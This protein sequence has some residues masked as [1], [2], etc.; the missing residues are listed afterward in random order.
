M[1]AIISSMIL[2]SEVVLARL[3]VISLVVYYITFAH[4]LQSPVVAPTL[5]TVY[6]HIIGA[7]PMVP[8]ASTTARALSASHRCSGAVNP[9]QSTWSSNLP[10]IVEI[11]IWHAE[12][13]L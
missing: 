3:G 5:I 7:P 4:W 12:H 2:H 10:T 6:F 8:M 13:Y 11:P 9:N 1:R